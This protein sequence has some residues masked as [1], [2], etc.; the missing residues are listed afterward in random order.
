[1]PNITIG[2]ASS[3]IVVPL[4]PFSGD[5]RSCVS[6]DY[7]NAVHRSGGLPVCIPLLEDPKA[8]AFYADLCDGFL[9]P[10]GPDIAPYFYDSDMKG[11][12]GKIY[13]DLDRFQLTLMKLV[14][15]RDK[16]LLG[17][18]RGM[19]LLNVAAGGTLYQDLAEVGTDLAHVSGSQKPEPAHHVSFVAGSLLAAL[20]GSGIWT[21]S[22]HHQCVKRTG[23]GISTLAYTDDGVIEA[24]QLENSFFALGVQW[25]PEMML[26]AD[27][28]MLP[29][30]NTLMEKAAQRHKGGCPS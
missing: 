12:R 11:C 28:A 13:H 29:I 1:M 18:C 5:E 14:L 25:H 10:G 2:I 3:K 23:T 21:N 4:E 26:T 27:E 6:Q 19:Q 30:F 20:L 24:I 15:E 9:F 22:F 16:P 17:I 8:L 7:I